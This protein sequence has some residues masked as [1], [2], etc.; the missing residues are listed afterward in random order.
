MSEHPVVE[1]GDGSDVSGE[2]LF[3]NLP[4]V[5][6]SEEPFKV[7]Y[8]QPA[9][10]TDFYTEVYESR[11]DEPIFPYRY[12]SYQVYRAIKSN[13][14]YNVNNYLNVTSQDVSALYPQFMYTSILR[15]ATDDPEF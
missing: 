4:N 7:T 6:S 2:T 12:G 3:N 5:T 8:I 13:N 9:N 10:Y 11:L 14:T 1:L 15:T